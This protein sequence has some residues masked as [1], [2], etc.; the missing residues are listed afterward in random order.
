MKPLTREFVRKMPKVV[1]HDHLDGGLRPRTIIELAR[2][3]DVPLYSTDSD[4]LRAWF[5]RG[6]NKG[7]LKEYLEGFAV[8]CG[9]MQTRD[10]LERVAEE[11]LDDLRQ[12]GVIYAELRFAPQFHLQGGLTEEEVMDAVLTGLERGGKKKD[13]R[14]GLI[15]CGM[16]SSPPELSL[17]MA[18]LA[19]TFRDRGC[20]GFDLAGDEFGHP[21]KDHLDAFHFCKRENFNITI[22]AGEAFGAPSIWQAL[23]YCGAH[24]IG[25]CT[26]LTEDM[27]IR[28]GRVLSMGRIA[29]YVLDHRVPLEICLSSNVQTGAVSN[30]E[31]HPFKYY[32]RH[33]FRITLNTD[34]RLMSATTVTDEHWLAVERFGLE[35]SDLEKIAINGMKSAFIR[36]DHRCEVIFD[37]LK[38]AFARLRAELDLPAAHYPV[39]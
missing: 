35:F 2:E 1:I 29:Q 20:V 15:V 14:W 8:T 7:N 13:I 37:V 23:Q 21:P 39:R 30:L 4:S 6:A 10:A 3:A 5:E 22:H 36:Y 9:V 16:R 31:S 32:L 33:K 24:R 12:D 38:P 18:E 27:V 34:N 25:H 28:D 19:I 17:K 26:R 11:A